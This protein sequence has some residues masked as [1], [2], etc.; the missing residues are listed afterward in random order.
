MLVGASAQ[1]PAAYDSDRSLPADAYILA[2]LD[3]VLLACRVRWRQQISDKEYHQHQF[4]NGAD[5]VVLVAGANVADQ[6]GRTGNLMEM[7]DGLVE[8]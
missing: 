1:E 8:P 5:G 2:E 6:D 4:N 3:K 7:V